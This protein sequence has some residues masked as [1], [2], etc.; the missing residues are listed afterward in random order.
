MGAKRT[1]RAKRRLSAG[2]DSRALPPQNQRREAYIPTGIREAKGSP[3]NLLG[4][5]IHALEGQ[6]GNG[7]DIITRL[8]ENAEAVGERWRKATPTRPTPLTDGQRGIV[9]GVIVAGGGL[10]LAALL[11]G[12][13]ERWLRSQMKL[14]P[15]LQE[16]VA[17]GRQVRANLVQRALFKNAMDGNVLAQIFLAKNWCGMA[18]RTQVAGKIEH[19][20]VF[21]QMVQRSLDPAVEAQA[22]RELES[23]GGGRVQ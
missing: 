9:I 6:F 21:P 22:R 2:A 10:A 8:E 15:E 17:M 1:S 20:H 19:S 3:G 11:I 5:F 12:R 18:D 16:Q 4:E 14:E 23:G 7:I 13:S